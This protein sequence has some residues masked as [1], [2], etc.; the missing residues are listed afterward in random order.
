MKNERTSL[1]QEFAFASAL[2]GSLIALTGSMTG[3]VIS[4]GVALDVIPP[5]YLAMWPI[6]VAMFVIGSLIAHEGAQRY[7][8]RTKEKEDS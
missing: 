2:L 1:K 4:A 5:E 6:P 7:D 3:V 8:C